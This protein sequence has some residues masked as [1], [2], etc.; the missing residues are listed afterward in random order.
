MMASSS[1]V[2]L[3]VFHFQYWV[4]N[5]GPQHVWQTSTLLEI[6]IIPCPRVGS[7]C[8]NRLSLQSSDWPSPLVFLPPPKHGLCPALL[9]SF[10]ISRQCVRR[11]D[12]F[13]LHRYSLWASSVLRPL[14]NLAFLVLKMT[15]PKGSCCSCWRKLTGQTFPCPHNILLNKTWFLECAL[16]QTYRERS[17]LSIDSHRLRISRISHQSSGFAPLLHPLPSSNR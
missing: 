14:V 13:S 10:P 4:L 16:K 12:T 9:L 5:L 17:Y 15:C 1:G 2:S 8:W 7:N 6:C 11:G 3:L